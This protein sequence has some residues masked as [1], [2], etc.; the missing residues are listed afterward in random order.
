MFEAAELRTILD[1]AGVPMKAFVLLGINCGFGQ[2]DIASLPLSAIDLGTGWISFPRPKTGISRRIPLWPET[3]AAIREALDSRPTPKD[4]Q[5][6]ELAFLT[7]RGQKWVRVHLRVEKSETSGEEIDQGA[8]P[9]DAVGKE[10]TKLLK[11]I[12]AA[13]AA[14][15]KKQ[16]A[17]A[18]A[19]L[20]RP[21][22]AFYALRN[23]FETVGA[24]GKDQVAVDA[25][26][27]HAREDMASV[28][29]ERISDDR[30]RAVVEHVRK[31]LF[32]TVAAEGGE[33]NGK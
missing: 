8:T 1:A 32:G 21:G 30:L 28:Y 33:Q 11:A 13:Q 26:M 10:F 14:N 22:R 23:G 5:D 4:K 3:I 20:K 18:T 25:I 9:D 12:D 24:E 29:R 7:A 27:G 15:A 19:K 2:T 16:G 17:K 6:R 31:W